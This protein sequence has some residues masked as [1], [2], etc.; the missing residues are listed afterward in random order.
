MVTFMK[1]ILLS[2]IV[3]LSILTS[4][5]GCKFGIANDYASQE[6]KRPDV[7]AI[8]SGIA[9]RLPV[10]SDPVV[11]VLIYRYE[12][13][14]ETTSE[15]KSVIHRTTNNE[16]IENSDIIGYIDVTTLQKSNESSSQ[17]FTYF[18]EDKNLENKKTYKYKARYTYKNTSFQ[19]T[20]W[21]AEITSTKDLATTDYSPATI[22]FDE[23]L[24]ELTIEPEKF[25]KNDEKATNNYKYSIIVRARLDSKNNTE[26]IQL[27]EI[28]SQTLYL[29][30]ILPRDFLNAEGG[31]WIDGIIENRYLATI[32]E[33]I[34]E[35]DGEETTKIIPTKIGFS[36]KIPVR[37][38]QKTSTN[39]EGV[40]IIGS[41]IEYKDNSS[42]IDFSKN[43][44]KIK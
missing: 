16:E 27:F 44:I 30:K 23:G 32:P 19:Y 34:P 35:E 2:V 3:L 43:A 42:G 24:K 17:D 22:T 37:Y 39:T 10:P 40:Q 38:G 18:F 11:S 20:K 12:E 29:T 33:K 36:K 26:L 31:V 6:L 41:K 25:V 8:D 21:S 14:T 4:F 9:I 28:N 7:E 13:D 15:K 5:I 1:K